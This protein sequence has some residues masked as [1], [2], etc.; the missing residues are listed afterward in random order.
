M[1][2]KAVEARCILAWKKVCGN[3]K[4]KLSSRA[5]F[6]FRNMYLSY[7]KI[8]STYI[9]LIRYITANPNIFS[10]LCS[11]VFFSLFTI[12]RFPG[13]R[14]GCCRWS[15]CPKRTL[16]GRW[17]VPRTLTSTGSGSPWRCWSPSSTAWVSSTGKLKRAELANDRN[18]RILRDK[19]D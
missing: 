6:R 4:A 2:K 18:W 3:R 8:S 9:Q 1:Q 12:S 11:S 16:W 19:C 10:G 15:R 13:A 17:P 14:W 7:H 5:N